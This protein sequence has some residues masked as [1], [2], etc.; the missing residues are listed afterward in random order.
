VKPN[1]A[2]GRATHAANPGHGAVLSHA[3]R[4][5]YSVI[6]GLAC[7]QPGDGRSTP[8]PSFRRRPE[9]IGRAVHQGAGCMRWHANGYRPAPARRGRM[10]RRRGP[11]ALDRHTTRLARAKPDS[12][13]LDAGILRS[14]RLRLGAGHAPVRC[15]LMPQR[16]FEKPP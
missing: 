4:P 6:T 14:P 11:E 12:S 16:Q 8:P 9:S 10:G 7:P 13:A 1:A 3:P 2:F 5:Y 15:A